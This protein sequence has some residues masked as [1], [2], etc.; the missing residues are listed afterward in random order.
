MDTTIFEFYPEVM[1]TVDR[2]H[3]VVSQ[4]IL[5][6]DPDFD[7]AVLNIPH[8]LNAIEVGQLELK[9]GKDEDL[10]EM[11]NK[12]IKDQEEEISEMQRWLKDNR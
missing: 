1:R 8:H 2:L 7:D 3:T 10:K 4:Q 5:I 6:G 9:Y 12:M 11:A